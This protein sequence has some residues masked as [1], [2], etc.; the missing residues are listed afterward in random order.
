MVHFHFMIATDMTFLVTISIGSFLFVFRDELVRMLVQ[1]T[2]NDR[3]HSKNQP[4]G[5]KWTHTKTLTFWSLWESKIYKAISNIYSGVSIV[6]GIVNV[7][8]IKGHNE[9]IYFLLKSI[10]IND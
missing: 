4:E 3:H 10:F 8:N 2:S 6:A 5:S 7:T 1:C 9:C